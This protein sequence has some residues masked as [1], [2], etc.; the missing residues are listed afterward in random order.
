MKLILPKREAA[1]AKCNLKTTKSTETEEKGAKERGG[2]KV[3]PVPGPFLIKSDITRSNNLLGNSQKD[4]A[5]ILG[6]TKSQLITIIGKNQF[7]KPPIK[8]G[9]T[10]KKIIKTAWDVI[11]TLYR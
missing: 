10:I 7:P 8:A 6:N 5:F 1:P 9:I 11:I 4:N 2:Y 3:H